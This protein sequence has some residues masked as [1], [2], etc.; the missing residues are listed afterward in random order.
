MVLNLAWAE[1][2]EAGQ[3]DDPDESAVLIYN[4]GD[5]PEPVPEAEIDGL[6]AWS[7]VWAES[8]GSIA[9]LSDSQ[10]AELAD[11]AEAEYLC[12]MHLQA[13][14][15]C[16]YTEIKAFWHLFECLE[17]YDVDLHTVSKE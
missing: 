4:D 6:R 15:G 2:Y 13:T 1:A 5:F 12:L 17:E 3:I 16:H 8:E 10:R 9:E 14:I 11:W 7:Y